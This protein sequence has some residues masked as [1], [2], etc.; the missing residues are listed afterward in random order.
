M[1]ALAR[2]NHDL[3]GP[4]HTIL[5][6]LSL[7]EESSLTGEQRTLLTNITDGTT[8]LA[9][10]IVDFL[11]LP[12]ITKPS[13]PLSPPD[14]LEGV[15]V[16]TA[17]DDPVNRA[18]TYRLLEYM[19]CKVTA[20]ASGRGCIQT[21]A[22]HPKLFNIV[23]LDLSMPDM[24]GFDTFAE[25]QK[26]LST[27][28][29]IVIALTVNSDSATREKC[30]KVGMDGVISKPITVNELRDILSLQLR[31]SESRASQPDAQ[32]PPAVHP[33]TTHSESSR[34]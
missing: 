27:K 1:D 9:E 6:L 16:L 20:A 28:R 8:Q 19:G 26:M 33:A 13:C 25:I 22:V 2:A 10:L 14:A 21:L 34:S 31:G 7:L 5:A 4:L 18:V 15:C 3:R 17:N 29:P 30:L 32:H 23:L 24:D 11:D 12:R